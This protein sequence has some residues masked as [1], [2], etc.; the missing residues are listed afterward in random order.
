MSELIVLISATGRIAPDMIDRVERYHDDYLGE[1]ARVHLEDGRMISASVVSLNED[2][3]VIT[4]TKKGM[5]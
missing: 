5:I 2:G 4:P 3:T 1:R